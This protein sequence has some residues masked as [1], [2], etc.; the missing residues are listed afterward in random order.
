VVEV[1]ISNPLARED[2]RHTKKISQRCLATV[3]GV[4]LDSFRLAL[5]GLLTHLEG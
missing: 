5:E 1:H 2:F 3:S 4:G